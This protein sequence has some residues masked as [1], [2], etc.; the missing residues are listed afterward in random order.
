M[1]HCKPV[2]R[3]AAVAI[4]LCTAAS[5][6]A[7]LPRDDFCTSIDML[8]ASASDDFKVIDDGTIA[9]ASR[10]RFVLQGAESCDILQPR[11]HSVYRCNWSSTREIVVI[12]T[13]ALADAL[14]ECLDRMPF[15][16]SDD[17]FI[18]AS[19]EFQGV[20]FSVSGGEEDGA[21]DIALSVEFIDDRIETW[22]FDDPETLFATV[23]PRPDGLYLGAG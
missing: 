23:S 22:D 1:W 6:S 2:R 13:L 21:F 10:T 14:G 9:P 8:T 5:A 12:Q 15:W 7:A 16:T 18:S 20:V 19:L 3:I 17:G 11:G 4:A